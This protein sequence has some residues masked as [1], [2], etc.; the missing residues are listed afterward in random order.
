MKLLA[1]VAASVGVG[2]YFYVPGC[3][4]VSLAVGMI[5]LGVC[6]L[7]LAAVGLLE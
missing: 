6:S 5:T 1:A 2:V 4:D 7:I 3:L